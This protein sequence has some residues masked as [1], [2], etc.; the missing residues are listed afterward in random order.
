[1]KSTPDSLIGIPIAERSDG[2]VRF[3]LA[4]VDRESVALLIQAKAY[5][6]ENGYGLKPLSDLINMPQ[7]VL[8]QLFNGNYPGDYRAQT[9][10]IA[11]YFL[12][13]EKKAVFGGKRDFVETQTALGLW[14]VFEKTRYNHRIQVIQSAEQLGKTLAAK[15]YTHRHN[16]GR[17]I[18]TTLM[19]EGT[20]NGFGVF[21]RS[22]ATACGIEVTHKKVMDIRFQIKRRL[23]TCDLLII[24]E[25]HQIEYWQD[26]A[27]RALID[28]IRIELHCDGERGIVLIA[29]NSD[30]MTLLD[31]FRKRAHYNVGQLLGRMCNQPL[32]IHPDQVPQRDVSKLV[33]RYYKPDEKTIRKLYKIVTSS[34]LGHFGL[35][36]DIMARAWAES[37]V[38]KVKLTDRLVMKTARETMDELKSRKE[39]YS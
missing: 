16:T 9:R 25:F 1:M 10:K 24:D 33:R 34:K 36:D 2:Q 18:M 6:A 14:K 15:E 8:S 5:A 11:K 37:Q 21:I 12:D 4:D 13:L 19:T 39:L 7:G 38:D 31:S 35:L 28:F 22:L 27:V 20:S 23:S 30:V 26:R 29:T 17:T 3:A 32:E